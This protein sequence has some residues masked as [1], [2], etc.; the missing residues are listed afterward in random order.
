MG[1]GCVPDGWEAGA[2]PFPPLSPP[3]TGDISTLPA[4]ADGSES[5]QPV[6][7]VE[8][9]VRARV[10]ALTAAA[11]AETVEVDTA[12][13]EV[14]TEV[15]AAA[16]APIEVV[17]AADVVPPAPPGGALQTTARSA[18]LQQKLENGAITAEE[19][20]VITAQDAA[21][22]ARNKSVES[23]AP[24]SSDDSSDSAATATATPA[25]GVLHKLGMVDSSWDE[26]GF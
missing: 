4:T 8:A 13:T 9:D 10:A 1:Y 12:I 19:Y 2:L 17:V 6:Q 15:T 11:G 20:T 22:H 21:A 18:L 16:D 23:F 7:P 25:T 14:E 5:V 26:N 24:T 3:A